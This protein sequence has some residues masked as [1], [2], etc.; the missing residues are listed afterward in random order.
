MTIAV[1]RPYFSVPCGPGRFPRLPEYVSSIFPSRQF[2]NDC[3]CRFDSFVSG[4]VR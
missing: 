3:V 2:R 4:V 1:V